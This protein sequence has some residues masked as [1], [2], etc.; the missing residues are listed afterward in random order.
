MEKVLKKEILFKGFIWAAIF[1]A[2]LPLLRASSLAVFRADDFSFAISKTAEKT[3]VL[4]YALNSTLEYWE[5]LNGAYV[6]NFF[7]YLIDP[8]NWYNYRLLR[9]ILMLLLLLTII[10]LICLV[11]AL[12]KYFSLDVDITYL[13]AL[14][15]IPLVFYKDYNELYMWFA[16]AMGYL[17]PVIGFEFGM[18]LL[19]YSRMKK[20]CNIYIYIS[21]LIFM[22]FMVGCNLEITGFAMWFFLIIILTDGS[23]EVKLDK[24]FA[25][26]F[27][28]AFI[29]SLLNVLAPGYYNRHA[30]IG[31]GKL[32][33]LRALSRSVKVCLE[34]SLWLHSNPTFFLFE[35]FAFLLG[36]KKK[37]LEPAK[38]EI[39][40]PVIGVVFLPIVTAFPVVLGYSIHNMSEI[41]N[42]CQFMLDASLV[43]CFISCSAVL[44]CLLKRISKFKP[45]K[46]LVPFLIIVI[47]SA[48]LN[49]TGKSIP[50]Q[51]IENLTNNSIYENSSRG[52]E[53]YDSLY[54][55]DEKDAT[56]KMI[57]KFV[58]G[59]TYIDISEDPSYWINQDMSKYFGKNSITYVPEEKELD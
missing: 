8:L 53:L 22:V 28:F 52:R 36:Y 11:K 39:L 49:N 14:I 51:I 31:S 45:Y 50:V 5:S 34:E 15:A 10:G 54:Y 55:S 46:L 57:P 26:A 12:V 56:V 59:G 27:V 7:T 35:L 43:I 25:F 21:A 58:V 13:V 17:L 6:C 29:F 42:R 1:A 20:Q 48:S 19:L 9:I 41:P 18:S 23:K 4:R 40:I 16:G 37:S 38:K 44:G 2:I 3:N 24:W 32:N 47:I 33:Y 30:Q